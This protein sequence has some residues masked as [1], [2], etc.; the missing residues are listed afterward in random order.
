MPKEYLVCI[1]DLVSIWKL[2]RSDVK[3]SYS[4]KCHCVLLHL[5]IS[6]ITIFFLFIINDELTRQLGSLE[7]CRA[8]N[9]LFCQKIFVAGSEELD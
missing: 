4:F 3:I 7:Y 2:V 9:G 5:L 1:I 8:L 6:L